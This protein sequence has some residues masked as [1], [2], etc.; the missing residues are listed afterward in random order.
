M[1][2]NL[3]IIDNITTYN[4]NFFY[5]FFKTN[6]YLVESTNNRNN[7]SHTF[8]RRLKGI[9][10]FGNKYYE[11][12]KGKRWVIY[13]GTVE[14]STIPPNWYSWIHFTNNK[15]PNS[16]QKK[17]SWEKRHVANLTGTNSAYRPKKIIE[18]KIIKR[19]YETW[20]V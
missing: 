20:K 15:L 11:S 16:N 10:E 14:A 12:K 9:D 6:I 2:E 1:C 18:S 4:T 7:D 5:E 17:Y 8:F 19:K 13:K 3:F